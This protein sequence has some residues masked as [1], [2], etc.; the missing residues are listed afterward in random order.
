MNRRR[1]VVTGIGALTPVGLNTDDFWDSLVEG[2]NGVRTITRFDAS[3]HATTIGAEVKGFNPED[4]G[5]NAK[6]ARRLDTFISYALAACSEAVS[7]SGLQPEKEDPFRMGV[8]VGSG[9]G[10][11]QLIEKEHN[12]FLKSGPRRVSPFLIPGMIIDMAAGEIAMRYGM[13][14]VNYGVVSACASSAHALGDAMRMIRCSDADVVVAG[15]SE[16]SITELGLAG[17][18]SAKALSKRNDDPEGASRPFDKE[19]D[20][21]V[22][23]EGAGFLVLEEM[24]RAKKRGARIYAELSGYGATADAYHMTAPHPEGESGVRA[25]K[26][27]I[28]DA[29]MNPEDIDYINAH[30]TSTPLN[31]KVETMVIKKVLGEKAYD[32]AISSTKSMTGHLL[33]AAGAVESIASIKSIT[34]GIIHPT[35]NYENPDPECDLDYVPNQARECRVRAA[36]TNSLGFGGHNATLV[37]S[38]F[39]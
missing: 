16:A 31:D 39:K 38:E 23:G 24:E 37:F 27:A 35:I 29:G 15:G 30:G 14:G 10:G 34:E 5:L 2:K 36:L 32:V 9:I 28:E 13:K 7:D 20:G 33:G 21:F 26:N 6:K 18:C 22:M 8:I 12:K 3:K 19:R 4:F 25:M 17:F 1:V 11:L